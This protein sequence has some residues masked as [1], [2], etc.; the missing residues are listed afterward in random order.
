L[1][2]RFVAAEHLDGAL[3]VARE[4]N[5]EGMTVTLDLLGENVAQIAEATDACH[6]YISLLDRIRHLGVDGNISIKLTMLG[7]DISEA[8]AADQLEQLVAHAATHDNFVRIDMEGS[9]YTERTL[10]LFRRVHGTYPANV[11]IVLQSC[12]YRTDRDVD[13]MIERGARVRLVKGAYKEPASIAYPHK[14]D[15]DAAYRRQVE[16]LL[17]AGNY[18]AIATHDTAIIGMVRGY[19]HRMGIDA[20]RFEFQMLYGVRRDLQAQLTNAGYHVRVYV[21]YGDSWYPYFVRRLAERPANMLFVARN[22]FKA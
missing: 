17:E 13:E 12:L 14:Q 16:R 20:S 21:P 11:G 1:V 2:D 3:D 9:A 10:A 5:A 8:T 6:A 15:V 7:L 4:S 19:A 18:P 22:L